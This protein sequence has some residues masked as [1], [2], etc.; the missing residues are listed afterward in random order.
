MHDT[1]VLIECCQATMGEDAIDRLFAEP[2]MLNAA[3]NAMSIAR[4]EG[5]GKRKFELE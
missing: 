2:L 5:S 4:N 3:L 1:N